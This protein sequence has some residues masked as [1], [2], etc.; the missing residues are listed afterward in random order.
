[1]ADTITPVYTSQPAKRKSKKPLI[2][3]AVIVL[4]A[5]IAGVAFVLLQPKK[6]DEKVTT[7]VKETPS[8]TPTEKPKIDKTTVKIQV[9]NGTGT[10]GQAGKAVEALKTAGFSAENIK[11]GNAKEFDT[12]VTTISYKAGFEDVA[13]DISDALKPTFDEIKIESS[14]LDESSDFDI[15]VVTGGKLY[16]TVAPTAPKTTPTGTSSSPSPTSGST[17][18]TPAPSVTSTTIPSTTP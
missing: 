15:V 5:L 18:S 10:P 8:P 7:A 14:P 9:T 12:T 16:E 1:M 4:I 13:T 6:Q 3:I 17:T 2:I 11:T